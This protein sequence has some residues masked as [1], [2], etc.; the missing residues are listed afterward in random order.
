MVYERRD[1]LEELEL[2]ELWEDLEKRRSKKEIEE[3]EKKIST[4]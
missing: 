3:S 1:L 2:T 4:S